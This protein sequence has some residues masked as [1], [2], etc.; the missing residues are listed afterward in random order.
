MRKQARHDR[1]R[2]RDQ[3]A[4]DHEV[5]AEERQLPD[6]RAAVAE[7]RPA[8]DECDGGADAGADRDERRGDREHRDRPARHDDAG[9]RRD[10]QTEKAR[11]G[12]D[13]F[14]H[15]VARHQHRDERRDQAGRQHLGQDVE[16]Q[17]DVGGEDFE[18][19][20]LA[21][22]PID[23]RGRDHDGDRDERSRP[24]ECLARAALERSFGQGNL[25]LR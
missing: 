13:P 21:V 12:P 8:G 25:R 23:D 1:Q 22:A 2:Q 9:E 7:Q 15:H 4:P 16:E 14:H 17:P 10:D 3:A 19:A 24:V 11:F 18:K 20:R 6:Q 5:G